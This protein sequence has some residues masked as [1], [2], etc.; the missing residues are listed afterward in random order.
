MYITL[1]HFQSHR[2]DPNSRPSGA[3]TVLTALAVGSRPLIGWTSK[4]HANALKIVALRYA[5]HMC[6]EIQ[7]RMFQVQSGWQWMTM[8][9]RFRQV[10]HF[11]RASPNIT[12]SHGAISVRVFETW[13][14]QCHSM[15]D[16][17]IH[18]YRPYGRILALGRSP[19]KFSTWGYHSGSVS[20]NIS[21]ISPWLHIMGYPQW[22][23]IP[24][25][26]IIVF[27]QW[28]M[29]LKLIVIGYISHKWRSDNPIYT[30]L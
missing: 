18:N 15:G 17:G 11:H 26:I 6:A 10:S 7:T 12:E 30:M 9:L 28:L 20:K 22:P 1:V 21:E 8:S 3:R 23:E 24:I 27:S 16:R 5:S 19:W 13:N 4:C 14:H 2:L 25:I 29:P